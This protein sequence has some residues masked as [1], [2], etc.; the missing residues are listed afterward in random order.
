MFLYPDVQYG[1]FPDAFGCTHY[2][3]TV[4]ANMAYLQIAKADSLLLDEADLLTVN[5]P[6]KMSDHFCYRTN[7]LDK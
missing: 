5:L 6:F 4:S 1:E 7:S 3:P 2:T